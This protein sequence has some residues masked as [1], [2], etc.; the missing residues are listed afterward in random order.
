MTQEKDLCR[1]CWDSKNSKQNPLIEPCECRGSLRFV[2]TSCLLR[3]RTINPARNGLIC[4][5]CME[6]YHEEYISSFESIPDK[7]SLAVFLLR[8]PVITFL[9][10]NYVGVFTYSLKPKHID[11][12]LHF[13]YYQYYSQIAYFLLFYLY[14]KVKDKRRYWRKWNSVELFL[15]LSFQTIC[16]VY[17]YEEQPFAFIPLVFVI[18]HFWPRH[19]SILEEMNRQ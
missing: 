2:H 11:M 10:V 1:F 19:I 16:N 13:S 7:S 5:L 8:Y 3:W 17:L 18:G 14:W 6:P 9:A 4:L 12:A 15:L